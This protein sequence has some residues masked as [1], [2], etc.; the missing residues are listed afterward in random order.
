[1]TLLG[2]CVEIPPR[3][4]QFIFLQIKPNWPVRDLKCTVGKFLILIFTLGSK[5]SND[6]VQH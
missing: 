3:R 5:E 4:L 2:R 1:M 6:K